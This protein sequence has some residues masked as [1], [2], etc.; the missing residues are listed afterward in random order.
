MI[1]G[2]ETLPL[3]VFPVTMVRGDEAGPKSKPNNCFAFPCG[4][5]RQV[6]N[7]VFFQQKNNYIR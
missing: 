5:G 1:L 2:Q 4:C 7:N 6:R 3:T